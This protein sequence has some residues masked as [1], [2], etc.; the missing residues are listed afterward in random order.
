MSDFNLGDFD[1]LFQ[2]QG[3][4]V[5]KASKKRPAEEDKK[6]MP[7]LHDWVKQ[8]DEQGGWVEFEARVKEFSEKFE[9]PFSKAVIYI[10]FNVW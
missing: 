3:G 6:P 7:T 9:V 2:K 4:I 5:G 10:L 1:R 8:M